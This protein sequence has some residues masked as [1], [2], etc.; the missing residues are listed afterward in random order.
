MLT[1]FFFKPKTAYDMRISY[2]SSDVCSSDLAVHDRGGAHQVDRVVDAGEEG[3]RDRD[4]DAV[5]LGRGLP[6]AVE[7]AI[8]GDA[9]GEARAGELRRVVIELLLAEP[10]RQLV[11]R[12]HALDEATAV[13]GRE[14]HQ[15]DLLVGGRLGE[16]GHDGPRGLAGV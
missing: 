13:V 11:N 5:E 15:V 16:P 4:V 1:L 3:G 7:V 2:W 10:G 14:A 8:P 12:A 9:A 6:V